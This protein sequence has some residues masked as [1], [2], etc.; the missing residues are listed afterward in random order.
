[1]TA[2]AAPEASPRAATRSGYAQGLDAVRVVAS[3]IV[4]YQHIAFWLLTAG[5]TVWLS[6]V[7]DTTTL[8]PLH[9]DENSGFFAVALF[10]LVSGFGITEAS[11]RERTGQFLGRRA[12]RLLPPLFVAAAVAWVLVSTGLMDANPPA[13]L[14]DLFANLVLANYWYSGSTVLPPTWTLVVEVAFYGLVALTI[15]LHRRRPWVAPALAATL[16]SV[17]LSVLRTEDTVATAEARTITLYLPILFLGQLVSLVRTGRL[18][19]LAGLGYGA[20]EFW[21]FVRANT[22]ITVP[23]QGGPSYPRI[24]LLALLVV[25]LC[26]RA[27]GPIARARWVGAA[28]RRTYSVYLMHMAL[29]YPVLHLLVPVVGTPAGIVAALVAVVAGSELVYRYVENP[30]VAWYRRRERAAKAAALP[31]GA[32]P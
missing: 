21:L 27:S 16:V 24:L 14:P 23:G 9:L 15:P 22:T 29:A 4:I 18:H 7:L 12:S 20:V 5:H 10:F 19:P 17:L 8:N 32:R 11:G 28:A 25:V 26:T 1:V 3:L 6:D 30:V 31:G 2:L 13:R